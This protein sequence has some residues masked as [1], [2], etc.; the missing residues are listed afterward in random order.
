[1]H[2]HYKS[3]LLKCLSGARSINHSRVPSPESRAE[4][5]WQSRGTVRP[6]AGDS[7]LFVL[8]LSFFLPLFLSSHPAN[9]ASSPAGCQLHLTWV[10]LAH[11]SLACLGQTSV[12]VPVPVPGTLPRHCLAYCWGFRLRQRWRWPYLRFRF[13]GIP[14][15]GV[16]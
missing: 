12:A 13:R 11:R 3:S 10:S 14:R 6:A 1:M 9:D 7:L 5:H 8:R 2:L 15:R 4:L 16:H